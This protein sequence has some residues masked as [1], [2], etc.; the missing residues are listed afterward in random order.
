MAN[1]HPIP[2]SRAATRHVI[3]VTLIYVEKPSNVTIVKRPGVGVLKSLYSVWCGCRSIELCLGL[4]LTITGRVWDC[5]AASRFLS[6]LSIIDSHHAFDDSITAR[7]TKV[8]SHE[9]S[10][11]IA[12]W[13]K[14]Q[15]HG[16]KSPFRE[17]IL[18]TFRISFGK[19]T[20]RY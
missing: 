3:L 19:A 7:L 13:C 1:L 9:T 15:K 18:R 6:Q 5:I 10:M 8:H 14:D 2:A 11:S 20:I 17:Y 16:R 4:S 12:C